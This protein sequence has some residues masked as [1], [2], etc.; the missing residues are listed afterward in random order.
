MKSMYDK[1]IWKNTVTT[2]C[3]DVSKV[4][5]KSTE[6]FLDGNNQFVEEHMSIII[7]ILDY[8]N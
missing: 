1:S 4:S 2:K 6:L 3:S 5:V 7:F 8:I